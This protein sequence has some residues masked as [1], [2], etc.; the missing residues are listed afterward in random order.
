MAFSDPKQVL[1]E[2]GIV[3]GSMVA[4]FGAGSGHYAVAA[5]KL[6]GA[7]GRV[8]AIDIQKDL[9][10]RLKREAG[11]QGVRNVEIVWGDLEA[12]G[13]SKLRGGTVDTVILANT[14]FQSEHR[15]SLLEEAKRVLRPGGKLIF[16]EWSESFGGMGPR[17]S[18]VI[19]EPL[20]RE[21]LTRAGFTF[22]RALRNVGDHHYGLI[23]KKS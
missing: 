11:A 23:V 17:S 1:A 2:S 10:N 9:L 6:V 8:Y 20:A 5:G 4:E 19:P 15:S 22:E 21:L 18:D 13:G 14:L 16:I 3:D 7:R 12:E